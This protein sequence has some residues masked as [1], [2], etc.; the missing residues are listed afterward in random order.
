MMQTE[1][2]P[3][4]PF[5]PEDAQ[6]LFLGSF[7]PQE[8]RWSMPF[9]YPNWTN[10]FWRVMGLL[11]YDDRDW[12]A[13]AG[14]KCFDI[15]K[16]KAFCWEQH[17]ALYDTACEVRRL[18]DNASDKFLEVVTPTDIPALL[19][20]IPQCN[21]LVTTG[22]KATDVIVETFGCAQ[23]PMGGR[24]PLHVGSRSITFWR[25]PS[26][27]RAYPLPLDKKASAYKVLF[28]VRPPLEGRQIRAAAREDVQDI[29]SVIQEAKVIMRASGN[30]HQWA[31]SYPS[32]DVILE[33]I[34]RGSAF[35][36]TDGGSIVAYFAFIPSPDPTYSYIEG[37]S[38]IED[39]LPYHVIHRIASTRASHG[40]FRSIR[41]WCFA[42]EANIRIDTHRDN[43][44]M[45]H[46]ILDYGFSYRGIIYLANGDERLAY[47]KLALQ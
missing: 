46:C 27:S 28:D 20:R 25:M 31:D 42:N 1:R 40:V 39:G 17:L 12:F 6:I 10:D 44:I 32:A 2:H 5:L 35:V 21:A 26:T 29:L 3:F 11:F 8:K 33:D 47:Q 22:Q 38:W 34:G 19:E 16:V 43:R 4:E 30:V 41:D 13:V 14:E 7:P 24:T 36:V 37:G 18:Q 23:P 15:E 45:Q 9:Y